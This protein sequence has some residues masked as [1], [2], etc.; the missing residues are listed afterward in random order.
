[1]QVGFVG[2]G[3]MGSAMVRNLMKTGFPV[4]V[5]NRTPSKAQELAKEGARAVP[6]LSELAQQSDVVIT[7]VND[8]PDVQE[9]I[10]G[11]RGL[12]HG[13]RKAT[14]VVDMSTISPEAT[15]EI[16][17]QL[18][19][20][21]CDMLDAPVSGGDV[22]ARNATLTIMV[23]GDKDVFMNMLSVFQALGKN[24]T[25]CGGHGDGQRVKMI[26]QIFTG[27]HTIAL[28]EGFALAK[29]LGLNLNIVHKVVSSG[30]AGSWA[31]DNYGPRILQGD[32]Q[33]GF[34][35]K[36]QQK[37][38]RIAHETVK[39]IGEAFPGTELAFELF[40]RATEKGLGEKGS[41]GL[42]QLYEEDN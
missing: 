36:M 16:A 28:S 5:W 24:I 25:H 1:M 37:D 38:L 6:S 33:P 14:V 17:A 18:Q 40:T 22:G 4:A 39:K 27:L 9:V 20:I 19:K 8:T 3:I 13:L 35:L 42:I 10:L 29:K 23:G 41:H 21:G 2:L 26:N 32:L 11:E 30:A 7:M 12:V 31:L 34:K 15:E